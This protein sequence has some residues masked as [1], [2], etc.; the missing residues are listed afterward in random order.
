MYPK[1]IQLPYLKK[2][3]QIVFEYTPLEYEIL[4]QTCN[5][6]AFHR[7]IIQ[8][9]RVHELTKKAEKAKRAR[10]EKLRKKRLAEKRRLKRLKKD[11]KKKRKKKKKVPVKI[12]KKSGLEFKIDEVLRP[13]IPDFWENNSFFG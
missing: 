4:K 8:I 6:I 12:E 2:N 3:F 7:H 10:E 5:K 9:V 11:K 1:Q 13:D